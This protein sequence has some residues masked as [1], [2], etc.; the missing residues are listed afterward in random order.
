MFDPLTQRQVIRGHT[1]YIYSIAF[2]PDGRQLA[3]GSNDGTVR[4]WDP[5]TGK[6][7]QT[8]KGHTGWV[9]SR[10][11]AR[12]G[13]KVATGSND[14]TVWLWDPKRGKAMQTLKGHTGLER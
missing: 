14:G 5:K 6:A 8:L 7:L 10:S 3:S 1:D 4:L 11:E 12:R 13:R 2:S 9:R